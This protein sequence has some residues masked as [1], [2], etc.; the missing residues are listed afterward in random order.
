MS[1]PRVELPTYS[2]LLPSTKES[3]K[4]RPYVVKEEKVL[5]MAMQSKDDRELKQAMGDIV[6][7]CTF[8]VV[9]IDQ[10]PMF[11]VQYV[12]LKLRCKSV[13]EISEVSV[14][15]GKCDHE[16]PHFIDLDKIEVTELKEQSNILEFSDVRLKIRYPTVETL[17]RIKESEDV[18]DIFLAI[19]S[20]IDE[21]QTEEEVIQNT[22]ETQDDFL[23]FVESLTPDHYQKIQD[24]FTFMP[25]VSHV[26]QFECAGC[27]EANAIV[28]DGLYNFFL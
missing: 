23:N 20:C 3:V 17:I 21:I 28:V 10:N 22:E 1:F 2:L 19:V 5:A 11:D 26:I 24:F 7:A 9:D 12:F 25:S 27:Q 8:G 15:C 14:H 6:K 4:Y 13:G 16:Q 18:D